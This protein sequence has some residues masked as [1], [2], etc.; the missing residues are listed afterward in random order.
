MNFKGVKE[1]LKKFHFQQK[2][3]FLKKL[4]RNK[5]FKSNLTQN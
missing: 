5:L 4:Y 3:I 2:I 1:A